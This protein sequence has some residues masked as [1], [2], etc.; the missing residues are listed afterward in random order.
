VPVN[1]GQFHAVVRAAEGLFP[2]FGGRV[3]SGQH[4]E[5]VDH[6][7]LEVLR[8]ALRGLAPGC[9]FVAEDA[10]EPCGQPA[11]ARWVDG[12]TDEEHYTCA[13]HEAQAEPHYERRALL[14]ATS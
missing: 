1:Y 14:G 2:T 3:T 9:E 10:A 7:A 8:A 12:A 4:L 13:A 11:T 6:A 5:Y